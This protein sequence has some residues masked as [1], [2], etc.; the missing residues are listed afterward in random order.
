VL[1]YE[2]EVK[3]PFAN[4]LKTFF[5]GLPSILLSDLIPAVSSFLFPPF[6]FLNAKSFHRVILNFR[7][8]EEEQKL[9]PS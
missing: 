9:T 4:S 8:E 7:R 2:C 3:K 1:R 6:I 5:C